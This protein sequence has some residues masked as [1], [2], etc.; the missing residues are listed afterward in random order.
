V[1]VSWLQR[2]PETTKKSEAV[3]RQQ[4]ATRYQ[5]S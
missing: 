3:V 2:D 4:H 1:L 5:F